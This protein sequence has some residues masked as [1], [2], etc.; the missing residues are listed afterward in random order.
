M[1][2]V[3]IKYE[4]LFLSY[5]IR[6]KFWEHTDADAADDDDAKGITITRLFFF[7]KT[8]KL[9]NEDLFTYASYHRWFLVVVFHIH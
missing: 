7:E 2:Q 8:D 9:I 5:G 6:L 3:L 1:C 4:E